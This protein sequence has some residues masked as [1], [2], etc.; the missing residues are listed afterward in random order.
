[1]QLLMVIDATF[2][3]IISA[4]FA[5]II[6]CAA[7]GATLGTGYCLAIM[8]LP[9]VHCV[10]FTFAMGIGVSGPFLILLSLLFSLVLA[11]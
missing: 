11:K 2:I 8:P 9:S 3:C 5:C 6:V 7:S 4:V 1:M 10:A